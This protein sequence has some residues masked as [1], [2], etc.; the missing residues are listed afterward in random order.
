MMSD[1]RLNHD[2]L[3]YYVVRLWILFKPSVLANMVAGVGRTAF[4]LPGVGRSVGAPLLG[5]A[6][7]QGREGLLLTSEQE[8]AL[9]LPAKLLLG[10]LW[11]GGVGVL[12]ITPNVASADPTGRGRHLAE[13]A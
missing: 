13:R 4:F 5:L 8:W 11:L 6:D 9:W 2:L 7:T 1:F 3:E 10:T 12:V